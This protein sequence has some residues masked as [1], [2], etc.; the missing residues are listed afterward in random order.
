MDNG[1]VEIMV[2]DHHRSRKTGFVYEHI[3]V[4]EKKLGRPLNSREVVHH[5][6]RVRHDNRPE[7]LMIFRSNSDHAIF[8][9]G[10]RVHLD[11]EG[12][13]YCD[14][15]E[16]KYCS[17]CGSKLS[18]G[19]N[20]NLCLKC[21]NIERRKIML[22]KYKGITKEKLFDMLKHNSFLKVGS[23]IGISDNMVRKL[24]DIFEIPRYASYYAKFRKES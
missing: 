18:N 2:K 21:N 16:I 20:G 6:N 9:S 22:S 7:N 12:V 23:Y 1:Y 4:A 8:H 17:S 10:G 3:I 19:T 24:C 13:A 14:H 15:I 5:I 11:D